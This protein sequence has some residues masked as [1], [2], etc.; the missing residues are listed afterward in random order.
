MKLTGRLLLFDKKDLNNTI[1]PKDCKISIPEKCPVLMEYRR[2]DPSDCIGRATVERDDKGLSCDLDVWRFDPEQMRSVFN[3]E[4][5][6]GGFYNGVESHNEDGIRVIDKMNLQA[7]SIT[8][9]PA[10]SDLKVAIVGDE[11]KKDVVE[12]K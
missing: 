5:F 10:D 3:D 9:L 1:F 11:L 6:V 8:L 4:I 7:V 12:E 2:F